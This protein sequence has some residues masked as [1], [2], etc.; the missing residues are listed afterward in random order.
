MK[1]P[2]WH[3]YLPS[4]PIHS[5][6]DKLDCAP[7]YSLDQVHVPSSEGTSL[8]PALITIA[9]SHTQS[10]PPAYS[11]AC[12]DVSTSAPISSLH[13]L[14]Q[15]LDHPAP[16]S[17]S[18]SPDSSLNFDRRMTLHEYS[19]LDKGNNLELL[20]QI[21]SQAKS[22][23]HSP[24]FFGENRIQGSVELQCAQPEDI[25]AVDVSLMGFYRMHA[26]LYNIIEKIF[27]CRT[28]PLR[29]TKGNRHRGTAGWWKN[30][31][32]SLPSN[33]GTVCIFTSKHSLPLDPVSSDVE[34]FMPLPPSTRTFEPVLVQYEVVVSVRW[35]SKYTKTNIRFPIEVQYTPLAVPSITAPLQTAVYEAGNSALFG[36]LDDPEGWTATGGTVIWGTM[37]VTRSTELKMELYLSKPL[38]YV[39]G[40]AI[41]CCVHI[42]TDDRQTLELLTSSISLDVSLRSCK[43]FEFRRFFDT[44][45]KG[46]TEYLHHDIQSVSWYQRRGV[47]SIQAALKGYTYGVQLMGE[48]HIH[49]K[50]CPSFSTECLE[51]SYTVELMPPKSPA[52]TF[53]TSQE[54]AQSQSDCSQSSFTLVSSNIRIINATKPNTKS[55]TQPVYKDPDFSIPDRY[56]SKFQV[57]REG[58]ELLLPSLTT[59]LDLPLTWTSFFPAYIP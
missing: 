20:V 25:K 57:W 28:C 4:W 49:P 31:L 24:M 16:H 52:F 9:R 39:C 17:L 32:P 21:M 48:I 47:S 3:R 29:N 35:H 36:P 45:P 46:N 33:K 59:H 10:R 41:P 27:Y 1:R 2:L 11:P 23:S 6:V 8:G 43:R 7:P 12:N 58:L 15:S 44:F 26:S 37:F 56:R 50:T 14:H 5:P 13:S 42:Y 55:I 19:H 22:G 18:Q 30:F 53:I 54:A 51:Q 38:E 34:S 40:T